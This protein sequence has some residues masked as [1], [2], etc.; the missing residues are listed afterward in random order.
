M[1]SASKIKHLK[2]DYSKPWFGLSD[3]DFRHLS[4]E[5]NLVILNAWK[6]NFNHTLS[7][8][9]DSIQSVRTA[10]DLISES[11]KD[12]RLVFVSSVSAV[13]NYDHKLKIPEALLRPEHGNTAMTIGYAQSKSV[14]ERILSEA[15]AKFG[16][17]ITVLRVGQIAG[18][19]DP[20]SNF[21][22]PATDLIPLIIATSKIVS[23]LPDLRNIDWIPIDKL[24]NVITELLGHD[25]LSE[26]CHTYNLVNPNPVP[27]S[28]CC[29]L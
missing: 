27:W 10:L 12:T 20:G 22:W 29:N 1:S 15:R 3:T 16:F 24:I 4:L 6:V 18:S 19:T 17:P 5:C 28:S 8:F 26:D 7:S 2:V 23:C 9:K 13:K 11:P 21:V 14:A 25:I